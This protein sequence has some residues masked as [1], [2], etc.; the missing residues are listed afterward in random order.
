MEKRKEYR[1]AKRS[2]KWLKNNTIPPSDSE[3]RSIRNKEYYIMVIKPKKVAEKLKYLF[4]L[5]GFT[6]SNAWRNV[7]KKWSHTH[8]VTLTFD[9]DISVYGAFKKS[10]SINNT[11]GN[12]YKIN[13]FSVV[14]H[15]PH[16]NHIHFLLQTRKDKKALLEIFKEFISYPNVDG[17]A[18]VKEFKTEEHKRNAEEYVMDKLIQSKKYSSEEQIDYWDINFNPWGREESILEPWQEKQNSLK[19][20]FGEL[21]FENKV[22]ITH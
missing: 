1:R 2:K 7:L 10:V 20:S 15:E 14:D 22:F 13:T 12:V 5:D 3:K 19:W 4:K 16:H 17:Y 11:L 21:G 18:Y 8:H 6:Y 9:Y